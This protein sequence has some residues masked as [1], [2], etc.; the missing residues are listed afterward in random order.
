MTTRGIP[1]S[2][3]TWALRQWVPLAWVVGGGTNLHIYLRLQRWMQLA[4]TRGPVN[5]Y[6]PGHQ[7]P[8]GLPLRRA[9][10]LSVTH[11]PHFP[12][13][14]HIPQLPLPKALDT[15]STSLRVTAISQGPTTRSS[16]HP[17]FPVDSHHCQGH[18]NQALATGP[19]HCVHLP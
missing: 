2:A 17:H 13:N 19:A 9:Q 14:A 8:Q 11:C 6:H 5:R 4:S 15:A 7:S 18:S 16:L 3:H 12:G 10:Q 1:F